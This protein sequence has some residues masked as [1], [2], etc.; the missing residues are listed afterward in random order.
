MGQFPHFARPVQLP[1]DAYQPGL[2]ETAVENHL[3]ASAKE[4]DAARKA[5]MLAARVAV[6][7][8]TKDRRHIAPAVG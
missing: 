2:A 4:I 7:A 5:L 3:S 6:V 8:V 1:R